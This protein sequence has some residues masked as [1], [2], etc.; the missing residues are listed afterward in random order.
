MDQ[1]GIEYIATAISNLAVVDVRL[2]RGGS[3]TFRHSPVPL[4]ADP[5]TPCIER[6]L[7]I[8]ENV[9]YFIADDYFYYGI[10]RADDLSFVIGPMRETVAADRSYR[11]MGIM[12]SVSP[13]EIGRF[14]T[15]AK[16]MG[17]MPFYTALQI[18]CVMG[19]VMN[20][21]QLGIEDLI[22]HD[23]A[24]EMLTRQLAEES[25]RRNEFRNV[26]ERGHSTTQIEHALTDLIRRGKT[27]ELKEY[28]GNLPTFRVGT[29][30]S[31]MLRHEKNTFIAGATIMSRAALAGG[32]DPDDA[33]T[34]S[35]SYINRCELLGDLENIND[36]YYHMCIEYAEMV[37][38]VRIGEDPSRL[39]IGVADY[40]RRHIFEPI[41]T[42][43][44]A[45]ALYVSRGFLSTR[46]KQETGKS[47][48]DFIQQE[49]VEEA[50]RLLARTSQ[51]LLSISTYLGFSSQSHFNTVFKRRTGLTPRA[52]RT[53]H[54]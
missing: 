50:K 3:L 31:D 38:R 14:I 20:G 16:S 43:D 25:F 18:L 1:A 47:L 13:E 40:V 53:R 34:L 52:Y 54:A 6:I 37:R 15:A 44:I 12:A 29:L 48:S 26:L 45:K 35:D 49:K 42:E 23:D 9:G 5:A 17:L 51:P 39:T 46:F 8:E 22:I 19:F 30:S 36:L 11:Q 33:L 32:V 28:L 2:Y 41:K 7:A 4:P 10:V 21:K 27:D 24:Q